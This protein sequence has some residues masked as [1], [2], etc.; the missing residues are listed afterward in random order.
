MNRKPTAWPRASQRYRTRRVR[1]CSAN[2]PPARPARPA[3][4]VRTKSNSP[5][6]AKPEAN[7]CRRQDSAYSALQPKTQAQL[8]RQA[9]PQPHPLP[10][11]K[12][13]RSSPKMKTQSFNPDRCVR[14]I[15]WHS[16]APPSARLPTRLWLVPGETRAVALTSNRDLLAMLNI[17]LRTLREL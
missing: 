9:L 5:S 4:S 10:Q 8:L 11:H 17:L 15:F 2:A 16:F 13:A 3:Q 12:R 14:V 1:S 6:S 7:L